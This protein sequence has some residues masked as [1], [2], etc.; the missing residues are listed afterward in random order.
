MP[1]SASRI[2]PSPGRGAAVARDAVTTRSSTSTGKRG[3]ALPTRKVRSVT[4]E[5][6]PLMIGV[7][8]FLFV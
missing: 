3:A 8:V 7:E 1:T 5:T 4:R 2:Y 6:Y